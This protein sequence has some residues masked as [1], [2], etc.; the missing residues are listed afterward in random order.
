LNNI[1]IAAA[2]VC[3]LPQYQG[4]QHHVF[5]VATCNT[6]ETE[7]TSA[8]FDHDSLQYKNRNASAI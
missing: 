2:F 8:A 3:I 4:S 1:A 6:T 7:A 5:V